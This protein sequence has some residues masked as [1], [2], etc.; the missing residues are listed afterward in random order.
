MRELT[1][2]VEQLKQAIQANNELTDIFAAQ[3]DSV[4]KSYAFAAP[5]MRGEMW[6][7]L[8][9]VLKTQF[10]DSH[11]HTPEYKRIFNASEE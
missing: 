5:E 1:A 11:S 9:A 8:G 7:R 2:V 6:G 4:A 10:P 3:L